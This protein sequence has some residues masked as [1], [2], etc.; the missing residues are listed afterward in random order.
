MSRSFFTRPLIAD[1]M[2]SLTAA[3]DFNGKDRRLLLSI[4]FV[5]LLDEVA[6]SRL[7]S[8]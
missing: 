7:K 5:K 6:D 1:A 2:V 4:L 3:A 8:A